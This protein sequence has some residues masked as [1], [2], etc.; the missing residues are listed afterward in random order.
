M[1][2]FSPCRVAKYCCWDGTSHLPFREDHGGTTL[3]TERLTPT[4][5]ATPLVRHVSSKVPPAAP[6]I[7]PFTS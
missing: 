2:L 3:Q 4:V 6:L 1:R 7:F 5:K